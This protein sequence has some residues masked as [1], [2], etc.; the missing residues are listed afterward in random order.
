MSQ[1]QDGAPEV[2][3]TYLNMASAAEAQFGLLDADERIQE[4]LDKAEQLLEAHQNRDGNY[5]FVCEKCATVFD[6]YGRFFFANELK[7]RSRRIY[8]NER[9]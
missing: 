8:G 7:E 6:Y 2:A 1:S 5:A 3:I 4:Y 9:A